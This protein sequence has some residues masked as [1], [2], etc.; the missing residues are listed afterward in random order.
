MFNPAKFSPQECSRLKAICG[1]GQRMG[2]RHELREGSADEWIIIRGL[3]EGDIVTR[4][5]PLFLQNIYGSTELLRLHSTIQAQVEGE[6]RFRLSGG[7]SVPASRRHTQ[8][9]KEEICWQQKVPRSTGR[10]YTTSC[11]P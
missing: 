3:A 1:K 9:L 11:E 2:V 7:S 4:R 10:S 5:L 6:L 8:A